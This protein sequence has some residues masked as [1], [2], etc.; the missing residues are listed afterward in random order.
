MPPSA[1]SI[2]QRA[3]YRDLNADDA[4][5]GAACCL[6]VAPHSVDMAAKRGLGQ[7]DP[8]E[9]NHAKEEGRRVGDAMQVFED[10]HGSFDNH[11]GYD[12]QHQEQWE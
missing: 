11:D 5:T 2:E 9:Q 1:A 4:D 6:L 8:E 7:D 3:E 12:H 10:N